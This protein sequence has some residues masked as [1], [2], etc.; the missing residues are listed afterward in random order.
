MKK[1]FLCVLV[2]IIHIEILS[3]TRE[4]MLRVVDPSGNP[5]AKTMRLYYLSDTQN[6]YRTGTSLSNWYWTAPEVNFACD[7]GDDNTLNASWDSIHNGVYRLRID[8]R[9]TILT[10]IE[11]LPGHQADFIIRFQNNQFT[12]DLNDRPITISETRDWDFDV[13]VY[14]RLD[15]GY[16]NNVGS[17]ARWETNSFSARINAPAIFNV[18]HNATTIFHPDTTIY[19]LQK[20][21][22]W[23]FDEGLVLNHN[24]F[25]TDENA[26]LLYIAQ[27][28][29]VKPNALIYNQLIDNANINNGK[30][31]FKDPWLRDYTD[32]YGKRNQGAFAV[33]R[34]QDSPFNPN[35][36]SSGEGSE[37]E[38][39]FLDLNPNVET[40]YYSLRAPLSQF[41]SGITW[42]FLNWS[43]N[44]NATLSQVGGNPPGYDQKAV[45][46]TNDN[47]VVTAN[48]KAQLATGTSSG[49]ASSGQR[50]VLRTPDGIINVVYESA[51]KIWYEYGMEDQS[52]NVVWYLGNN[53]LP[54]SSAE[55]KSPSLG[56]H[57]SRLLIIFQEKSGSS[58][59]KIALEIFE[60]QQSI[61]KHYLTSELS[62]Y[63]NNAH[64]VVA[65]NTGNRLAAVWMQFGAS[66]ALSYYCATVAGTSL[67]T[68]SMSGTLSGT[69]EN[70]TAPS[71][72]ANKFEHN[73]VQWFFPLAY[74]QSNTIQYRCMKYKTGEGWSV[75]NAVNVSSG[76]GF[77]ENYNPSIIAFG[78]D[79]A[80]LTWV[81]KR[82]EEG[83]GM[84]KG[85]ADGGYWLKKTIFKDPGGSTF[86][87]FES[88]VESANIQKNVASDG[89]ENGYIVAWNANSGTNNRYTRSSSLSQTIS[90]GISGGN[91]QVI[92]GT[93]WNTMY[94]TFLYPS[95]SLYSIQKSS[96]V[97]TLGKS[98][99]EPIFSGRAG[100]VAKNKAE[101]FFTMG[102]VTVDGALVTFRQKHDSIDIRS[103][104]VLNEY[105]TTEPFLLTNSS[106]FQYSIQYGFTDSSA[107]MEELPSG[108]FV[109][110]KVELVDHST[111]E[112]L[113]SFDDVTYNASNLYRY[114]K[115]GYEV[116]SDGI[117]T[118]IVRLRLVAHTDLEAQ[119]ALNNIVS[120][121]STVELG[122]S[123][124][125]KKQIGYQ[126]TLAVTDYAL[127]QNYPNP[128][129]PTTT[130]SYA[131]PQDG[132]VTIKIYDALGREVQTLVNEFKLTGRYTAEF[133]AS[134]LA[135]G[136]YVYKLV[137]GEYSAVKKMLLVK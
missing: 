130:I 47:A 66:P 8:D 97:G 123:T 110:F 71:L 137:S 95:G 107:T 93:S 45:V 102:D 49:Y 26:T 109:N 125:K 119:F 100:V 42:N 117:G 74:T 50:K 57:G 120:S 99:T 51:G 83:G 69:D 65:C 64:P 94:G 13:T 34:Q 121:T 77:T 3:M 60:G 131:L 103:E 89:T 30:I 78:A 111:N 36:N 96:S 133:D 106:K 136:I 62:G 113:G 114:G 38:G 98:Q 9:Y 58:N 112:V 41:V 48:Y 70:S 116:N 90:F 85:N 21:K 37:Y 12:I 92:G 4:M 54:V 14:Q 56:Y 27:L 18:K 127:E 79:G 104:A 25:T 61:Q 32:Q 81:G 6:P 87:N 72:D 55:A 63:A 31:E 122:K 118:R 11:T 68:P 39:V 29:P 86:W 135:S 67:T 124:S 33:F 129:N 16:G 7:I 2:F 105:M 40:H 44:S 5:I 88:G 91:V 22:Q 46:F 43:T 134:R 126:G 1:T 19:S 28:F 75:Q 59:Y 76:S 35:T 15:G 80:R 73:S 115:T 10:I 82:W 52:G 23:N 128:F 132:I 20:M 53:N 108:G 17:I 24:S 101:F 84:E